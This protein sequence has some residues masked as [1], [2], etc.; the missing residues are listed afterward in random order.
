MVTEIDERV[1]PLGPIEDDQFAP[2]G[3]TYG[4]PI[5]DPQDERHADP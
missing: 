4:N 5:R 2:C 3:Y 1:P